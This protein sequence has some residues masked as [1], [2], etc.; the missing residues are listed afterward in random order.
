MISGRHLKEFG[1]FLAAQIDYFIVE[2]DRVRLKNMPEP[3]SADAV[4]LDDEGKPLAGAKAKLAAVDFM[5]NELEQVGRFSAQDEFCNRSIRR[6]R[7]RRFRSRLFIVASASVFR[8][9]CGK[10]R[11]KKRRFCRSTTQTKL[12]TMISEQNAFFFIF[13]P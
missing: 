1:D 3:S 4:E 2:G 9:R 6:T 8:I 11:R 13:A 7:R 5:R 12:T 10:V